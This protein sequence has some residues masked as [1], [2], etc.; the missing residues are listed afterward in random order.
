[1]SWSVTEVDFGR[2]CP[3]QPLVG[4]VEG[5]VVKPEL[6][7]LL[8][9]G[10]EQGFE[11]A[12]VQDIFECSPESFDDGNGAVATNGTETLPS[13]EL[14]KG[15]AKPPRGELLSLIGDEVLGRAES[16]RG[17][18][19]EPAHLSGGG[20]FPED[21][22]GERHPREDIE[23]D[24][25]LE[26]EQ[27]KETGDGSDVG[28]PDVMGIASAES[29]GRLGW[30]FGKG[31]LGRFFFEDSADG[32]FGDLPTGSSEGLGDLL[33]ATETGRVHGMDEMADDI[34]IAPDR[35]I[36]LNERAHGFLSWV[37]RDFLLPTG[38]GVSRDGKELGGFFLGK[39]EERLEL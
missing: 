28:H 19:K 7:P 31:S 12:K 2:G 6:E 30:P 18:L 16:Q 14:S 34:G 1:M 39:P 22:G 11:R 33:A 29:T 32:A 26:G 27:S 20:F 13:A 24:H 25:E 4:S 37:G 35:R 5:V 8:Q 38:H 36:R 10:F 15:L 9:I 21:F 23:E 17:P 3:S